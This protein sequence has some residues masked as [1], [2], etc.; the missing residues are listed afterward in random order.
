MNGIL[1]C[2]LMKPGSHQRSVKRP[3]KEKPFQSTSGIN[4]NS[5]SQCLSC[6]C[7]SISFSCVF[8]LNDKSVKKKSSLR[9]QMYF[10][11]SLG[12]LRHRNRFLARVRRRYFRQNQVTAGNTSAFACYQKR[13]S[14]NHR[15]PKRNIRT[16]M[17]NYG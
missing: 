5:I 15:S 12:F 10:W 2:A 8:H 17:V 13:G 16:C 11:L 3:E 4:I 6:L 1:S 9:T 14:S 7:L